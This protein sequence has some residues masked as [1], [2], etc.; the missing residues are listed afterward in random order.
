MADY[1]KMY[2]TAVDAIERAMELLV[3]AEQTCEEIYIQTDAAENGAQVLP[4][5]E[6]RSERKEK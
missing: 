2:L 6:G 1:K 4:F 5:P 3:E